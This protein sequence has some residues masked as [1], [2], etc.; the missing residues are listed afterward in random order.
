MDLLETKSS[1]DVHMRGHLS[2]RDMPSKNSSPLHASFL[3]WAVNNSF[4]AIQL[5]FSL[6]NFARDFTVR[7]DLR[8]KEEKDLHETVETSKTLP[9]I[10]M[11]TNL[12]THGIGAITTASNAQSD[13]PH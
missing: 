11:Y 1:A 7:A 10:A 2:C 13:S 9:P 3:S 12:L 8:T 4:L 5:L 6:E